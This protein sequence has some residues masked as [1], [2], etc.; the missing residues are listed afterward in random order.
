M[1]PSNTTSRGT[2]PHE[3]GERRPMGPLSGSADESPHHERSRG[4]MFWPPGPS[5]ASAG[6][7]P[8][9]PSTNP[10]SEWPPRSGGKPATSR[11]SW[12]VARP[13][14][15]FPG[16]E[17]RRAPASW[18]FRTAGGCYG[19]S[20]GVPSSSGVASLGGEGR[21][22]CVVVGVLVDERRD[23][24]RSPA[25]P[26]GG[27]R[28]PVLVGRSLTRGWHGRPSGSACGRREGR[29]GRRPWFYSDSVLFCWG[30]RILCR[31]VL[32]PL[33]KIV[34]RERARPSS[35]SL[36]LFEGGELRGGLIG[37]KDVS[38]LRGRAASG[39]RGKFLDIITCHHVYPVP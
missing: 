18:S 34:G 7:I 5:P 11:T 19:R 15:S 31:T 33:Q 37:Q 32:I 30:G 3:R 35:C 25:S 8:L 14:A 1:P 38:A 21:R 29:E 10:S 2:A 12:D 20:A 39:G 28:R 23:G 16:D 6:L 36:L 17:R 4:P 27:R 22:R 9:L 26:G 24:R 13:R